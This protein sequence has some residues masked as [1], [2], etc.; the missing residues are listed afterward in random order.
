MSNADTYRPASNQNRTFGGDT[1]RDYVRS[2][3]HFAANCPM[4]ED[5]SIDVRIAIQDL[6]RYAVELRDVIDR[7]RKEKT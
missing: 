5:A 4:P 3:A 7:E 1:V 2:A 6:R